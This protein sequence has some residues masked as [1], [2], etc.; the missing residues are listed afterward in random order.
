MDVVIPLLLLAVIVL[1]PFVGY[2]SR[3][4]RDWQPRTDS[5]HGERDTNP[6]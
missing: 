3:D 2:D 4:G 5:E 6:V 1:A